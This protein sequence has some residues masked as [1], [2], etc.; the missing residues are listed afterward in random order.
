MR[1]AAHIPCARS[2][3][4]PLRSGNL[5]RPLVDGEPAFLRICEVVDAA[6]AR[7]WVTVAFVDRDLCLP[8]GNGTFFEV[9]E[10]A[11]ARGIDVRVLF[12]REPD[13]ATILP[14]SEHFG[15]T[16]AEWGWLRERE[17][18]F[19]A[20]WDHLPR[21][22]HHQKSWL[23][24]AGAAGE[25]AF[26]GG[27]NLDRGSMV[28]PG[29]L[30]LREGDNIHDVYVEVRGPAA[31]DVHHNFVQRWNEASERTTPRG[32]WPDVETAGDLPFPA[33]LSAAAGQ[34]PVQITRTVRAERYTAAVPS[35]GAPA[36]AIAA[37]EASMAEQYLAAVDAATSSIY[38]EN[39]FF[40]SRE[41]LAGLQL[42]L[43]RGIE[44]VY[45]LPAGPLTGIKTARDDARHAAVFERPPGL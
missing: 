42:A 38:F 28:A 45:L 20:R 30:P 27:I 41:I 25:V 4:Y 9:L 15:G 5:V 1:D 14:G 33:A 39:Q 24:D 29:H 34:V 7:V 6:R 11:V 18:R 19:L 36:F 2:G 10:R 21:Y 17:V 12:W 13:L 3:A 16:E 8:G 43:E 31:T 37:G 35:P 32:A 23:I 44:G 40:A 22:C 26:V